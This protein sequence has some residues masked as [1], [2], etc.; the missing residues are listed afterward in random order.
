MKNSRPSPGRRT[1]SE[2]TGTM[3]MHIITSKNG[4]ENYLEM[5]VSG[6][7]VDRA[8]W[9]RVFLFAARENHVNVIDIWQTR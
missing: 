5:E 4:T 7:S 9:M 3:T 2:E 1:T 6:T 8:E